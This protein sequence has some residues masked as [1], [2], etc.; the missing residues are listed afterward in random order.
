MEEDKKNAL[1]YLEDALNGLWS[2]KG[3]LFLGFVAGVSGLMGLAY[4]LGS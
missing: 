3:Y 4:F 1:A 2:N